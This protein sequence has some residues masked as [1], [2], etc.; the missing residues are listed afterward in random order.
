MV[1]TAP[2]T[3]LP[4]TL[5]EFINW[6]PTDGFKYE[7][8][9]G[10]LIR[11]TGM[12][13]KHLQLIKRLNRLFLT[14]ASHQ[15]GAELI[16]EQDVQLTGIQMRRPDMAFFTDEQIQSSDDDEPIP[17]FCIEVISSN[18][19]LNDVKA[20]LREYFK[21]GVQVVWIIMPEQDMVEVYTSVKN[22]VI[23]TD[24]DVCS[25]KPVLD[26]FQISV[27]ELLK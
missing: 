7:W 11:F 20:K 6:E 15:Q 3:A 25:A 24:A 14:T 8:N 27:S 23:C 26:D 12:K 22:V 5:D 4:K 17:A 18:D 2:E 9:D 19:Q 21:H 16:A 1:T 13:R 10:E